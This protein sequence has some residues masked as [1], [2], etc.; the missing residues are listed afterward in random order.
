MRGGKKSE[1]KDKAVKVESNH[2]TNGQSGQIEEAA[3]NV[4]G[5]S[6]HKIA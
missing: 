4:N 5:S 1:K 6:G 2:K 3:T